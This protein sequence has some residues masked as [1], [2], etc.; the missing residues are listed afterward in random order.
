MMFKASVVSAMAVLAVA[1]ASH[2]QVCFNARG[3]PVPTIQNPYL[4]DAAHAYPNGVIEVNPMVIQRLSIDLQQFVLAHECAHEMGIFNESQADCYAIKTGR[5]QG[6]LSFSDF[7]ELQAVFAT[8]PGD[9]SHL[10][11]PVRVRI[12]WA[13]YNSP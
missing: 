9:W 1:G 4:N 5:A 7:P 13:C 11:G 3:Q 12:M 6:W 10:P 2:A 8:S